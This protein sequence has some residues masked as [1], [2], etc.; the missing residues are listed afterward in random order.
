M[1]SGYCQAVA[2]M[3]GTGFDT[4]TDVNPGAEVLLICIDATP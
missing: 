3:T 1:P 4:C 2:A